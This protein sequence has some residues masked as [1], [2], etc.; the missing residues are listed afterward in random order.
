MLINVVPLQKSV[1]R[2]TTQIYIWTA[3]I[4]ILYSLLFSLFRIKNRGA[5]KLTNPFSSYLRV[6]R[7]SIQASSVVLEAI[8]E[9]IRLAIML[10]TEFAR[11]RSCRRQKRYFRSFEEHS[12]IMCREV[13]RPRRRTLS[14]ESGSRKCQWSGDSE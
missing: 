5:V 11:C 13:S 3:V 12:D 2:Q 1:S 9:C 7:I 8:A 14:A 6:S 4:F 10:A